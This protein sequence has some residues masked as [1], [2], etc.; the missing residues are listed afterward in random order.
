MGTRF[1]ATKEAPVHQNVKDAIVAASELDTRL[2]MRP[3]RNTERVLRNADERH[4]DEFTFDAQHEASVEGLLQA[5]SHLKGTMAL[6]F[7]AHDRALTPALAA[8][9][10]HD[11]AAIK[12]F[13]AFEHIRRGGHPDHPV[14]RAEH[15]ATYDLARLLTD[16]DAWIGVGPQGEH[17]LAMGLHLV[18]VDEMH[19][20][21]RAMFTVLR[22]LMARNRAGFVGVGDRDQVIHA[23][24]GAD[25]RF[26]GEAFDR[27][28]APATRMPLSTKIGRA[29]V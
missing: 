28:V 21:N 23:I 24:S 6:R 10:G 15:D 19:D 20:T 11:Y 4:P 22:E 14:F 8:E 16:E 5:F 7:E 3:L 2:V 18:L 1:I 27:E 26:M 25:A 13:Q 9:L 17:P 12:I 29:H